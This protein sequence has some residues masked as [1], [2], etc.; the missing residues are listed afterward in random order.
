MLRK[1]LLS[2]FW[3]LGRKYTNRYRFVNLQQALDGST[4]LTL[5]PDADISRIDSNRDSTYYTRPAKK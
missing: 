2:A 3:A 4:I 1:L 5:W